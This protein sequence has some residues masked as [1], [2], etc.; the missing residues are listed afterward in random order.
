VFDVKRLKY[1]VFFAETTILT[2]VAGPFPHESVKG[3]AHYFLGVA[4]R[5]RRALDLRMATNVTKET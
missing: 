1:L 3:V 5:S 2:P 4:A